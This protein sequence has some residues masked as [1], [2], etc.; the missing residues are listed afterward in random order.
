MIFG[1]P[2]TICAGVY[3]K[4]HEFDGLPHFAEGQGRASPRGASRVPGGRAVP[5]VG[6]IRNPRSH[7]NKGEG[8]ELASCSNILTETPRTRADLR[9]ALMEFARRGI[10]YL[11]I[12]GGDGTVRDALTCGADIYG[13]NWPGLIVLPRGKT[14]A[15][16]VDLGLPNHWSLAEAMEAASRG[17]IIKRRPLTVSEA[18]RPE[19]SVLGFILGAGVF[20]IATQAGQEAHRWGAFNSFAVG[21]TIL[22]AIIQTVFG[23]S[24]RGWRASTP[25]RLRD[26]TDGSELPRSRHGVRGERFML[27][28]STLEKFPLG[29][30]PFG[31]VRPGL[32]LAVMDFPL[33]RLIA[34]LPAIL[35]GLHNRLLRRSGAYQLDVEAVDLEIGAS[36]ILDGE[37]FPAGRYRLHQGPLLRFVTP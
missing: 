14:N 16:A 23:R 1:P 28:A 24:G 37:A 25:M 9:Q 31:R 22:W 30:R 7:R 29:I 35:I 36:F 11:V 26:V 10:D 34:L 3:G 8:P 20:T 33:R 32:K 4:I 2:A 21:L 18:G 15:L 13:E 19:A 17:N 6:I 27:V 5:L 12:D